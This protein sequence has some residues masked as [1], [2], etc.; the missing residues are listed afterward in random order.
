MSIATADGCVRTCRSTNSSR[1]PRCSSAW[2]PTCRSPTAT[3]GPWPPTEHG[4]AACSQRRSSVRRRRID[5]APRDPRPRTPRLASLRLD[6][7]KS[8]ICNRWNS[9]FE[10]WVAPSTSNTSPT[11]GTFRQRLF[12]HQPSKLRA[13]GTP[14][15]GGSLHQRNPQAPQ[16]TLIPCGLSN[17]DSP[18]LS[19]DP[20]ICGDASCL[21][22]R[23]LLLSHIR[24]ISS[25]P[26]ESAR[27]TA[28]PAVHVGALTLG[29]RGSFSSR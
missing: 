24:V 17:G 14:S 1:P 16:P 28:T 5:H 2:R 11:T 26:P 22:R 20:L 6:G 9:L 23:H 12:Q 10:G 25:E 27:A 21:T 7:V 8:A 19:C 13:A 18:V 3:V 15:P 4:S 29:V